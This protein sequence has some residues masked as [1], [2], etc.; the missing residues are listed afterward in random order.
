MNYRPAILFATFCILVF[1]GSCQK[2]YGYVK[3]VKKGEKIAAQQ[4]PIR[5]PEKHQQPYITLESRHAPIASRFSDSFFVNETPA[6]PALRAERTR[7]NLPQ[8][9]IAESDTPETE[10]PGNDY[11]PHPDIEDVKLNSSNFNEV[12][13]VSL[14]VGLVLILL[15]LLFLLGAFVASGFAAGGFLA[16]SA[17]GDIFL[18][19]LGLVIIYP[20]IWLIKRL[21]RDLMNDTMRYGGVDY[22]LKDIKSMPGQVQIKRA[23]HNFIAAILLTALGSVLFFFGFIFLPGVIWYFI[24][25]IHAL[26]FIERY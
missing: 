13:N 11:A 3:K 6:Y 16:A 1:F 12:A 20:I 23:W 7:N 24:K 14:I 17:A 8:R 4:K 26:F 25:L 10:D 5:H 2:R 15:L 9:T 19:S 22:P 18:A 21:Y